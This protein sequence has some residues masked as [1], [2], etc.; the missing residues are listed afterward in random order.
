MSAPTYRPGDIAMVGTIPAVWTWD[1][2]QGSYDWMDPDDGQF[3]GPFAA[4]IVG[5]VLGNVADIAATEQRKYEAAMNDYADHT[6]HGN[7][8]IEENE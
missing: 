6:T 3:F 2:D 4:E 7:S 8:W 5:P 1:A